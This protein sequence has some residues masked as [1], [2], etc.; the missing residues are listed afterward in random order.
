MPIPVPTGKPT[1]R[2]GS[3]GEY[4]VEVQTKLL[5]AKYDLGKSGADGKFGAKTAAA[6]KAFQKDHGLKAD[7]IVGKDTWAAL[8]AI[9]SDTAPAA[10]LYTVTIP[11]LGRK[12]AE[13]LV[14]KYY[15]ATMDEEK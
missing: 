4:V 6:V 3:T 15:P 10:P 14:E 11:H 5:A 8:D 1:L 9:G 13:E 12:T 7:G 2:N